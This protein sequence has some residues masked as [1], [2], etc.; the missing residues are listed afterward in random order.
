MKLHLFNP[1]NDLA[2]ADGSFNYCPPPA[3][4]AIAAEL[5]TLPLWYAAA[6]D[7]VYLTGDIHKELHA[8]MARSFSL[9]AIYSPALKESVSSLSPWGW[10]AQMRHRFFKAM[11]FGKDLLPSDAEIERMRNLSSRVLTIEIL[12]ALRDAG[13][14]TPPLPQYM[15][16][17]NDVIAYVNSHDRCVVKA[18]WS[19]SGKGLRWTETGM[20]S[21]SD[22]GWCKQI[23]AKQGSVMAEV[24]RDVVQDFAM[25]FYVSAEPQH[26][27]S[28]VGYSLFST[29]N[30]TYSGNLLASDSKILD[31]LAKYVP[32][33]VILRVK[34][35]V[36]E[37]LRGLMYGKY[38]GYIGVDMFICKGNDETP[39][40]LNSCVEINFRMTMGVVA[41]RY[42]NKYLIHTSQTEEDGSQQLKVVFARSADDF[43]SQTADALWMVSNTA[44]RLLQNHSPHGY[45]AVIVSNC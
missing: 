9:P 14:D 30:G 5:A 22:V 21:H 42:F 44:D 23:I 28:F 41:K 43:R 32:A 6:D 4:M 12:T 39:Y 8:A 13:I 27:V 33:D 19:G 38:S 31:V 10:S 24:R 35:S 16:D 1:E 25:L 26:S 17:L 45:Y 7:A 3:A 11:G 15:T 2:L 20:L 34:D 37:F 40:L 36:T 29:H 18:P